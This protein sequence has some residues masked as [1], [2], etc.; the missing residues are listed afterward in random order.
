MTWDWTYRYGR[1]L[2]VAAAVLVVVLAVALVTVVNLWQRGGA[3]A[4][5]VV[6]RWRVAEFEYQLSGGIGRFFQATDQGPVEEYRTDGSAGVD[7]GDGVLYTVVDEVF[8]GLGDSEFTVTGSASY[9]YEIDADTM[10]YHSVSSRLKQSTQLIDLE[11]S[12]STT[13]FTY[14]CD[15]GTMTYE[16]AG[17]YQARLVRLD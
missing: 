7:Y 11:S 13:P 6:G 4:D 9:Q 16:L 10:R 15:G 3:G 2:L 1:L 17:T 8:G 12:I 14:H 5:C